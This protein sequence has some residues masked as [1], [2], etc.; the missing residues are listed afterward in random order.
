M[1]KPPLICAP[2]LLEIAEVIGAPAALRLAEVHGG[3]ESCYIPKTARR[4]HP[5]AQVVGWEAWRALCREYGGERLDIPRNAHAAE[6]VKARMLA[7]EHKGM[8]RREIATALRCTER[9]VRMVL[10]GGKDAG[11]QGELF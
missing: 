10:N 9:Y 7:L 6:T 5:W 8:S 3:R 1:T 11:W 2:K 4:N